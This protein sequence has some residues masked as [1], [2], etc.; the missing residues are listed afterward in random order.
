LFSEYQVWQQNLPPADGALL[1]CA[2][3]SRTE[4]Y[5]GAGQKA[6]AGTHTFVPQQVC[7]A[8]TSPA[9]QSVDAVQVGRVHDVA[10]STQ[11]PWPS[12]VLTQTGLAHVAGVPWVHAM[13][14]LHVAGAHSGLGVTPGPQGFWSAIG[15]WR[16][17]WLTMQDSHAAVM[18]PASF[19]GLVT[20]VTTFIN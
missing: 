16:A 18:C 9:A 7:V 15:I 4:A 19:S 8:Q 6:L 2:P 14:V 13:K 11:K 12:V 20:R 1:C 5:Y 3:S 17:N 10:P